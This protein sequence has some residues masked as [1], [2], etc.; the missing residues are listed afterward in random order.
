MLPFVTCAYKYIVAVMYFKTRLYNFN[1]F[2]C[3]YVIKNFF[4]YGIADTL[5]FCYK[6]V[7]ILHTTITRYH[8]HHFHTLITRHHCRHFPTLSLEHLILS[9]VCLLRP[10]LQIP[11]FHLRTLKNCHICKDSFKEN[12]RFGLKSYKLAE[13]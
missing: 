9:L 12:C 1:D 8:Y 4:S 6:Q 5:G 7:A 10:T 2:F 13:T 11:I 3:Y